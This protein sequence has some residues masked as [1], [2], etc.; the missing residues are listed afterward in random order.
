MGVEALGLYNSRRKEDE[1]D[2]I[3]LMI[4]AEAGYDLSAVVQWWETIGKREKDLF[5]RLKRQHDDQVMESKEWM[6][7]HLHV[8][9]FQGVNPPLCL[10]RCTDC[11]Q[12]TSRLNRLRRLAPQAE[13]IV[14]QARESTAVAR[15]HSIHGVPLRDLEGWRAFVAPRDMCRPERTEVLDQETEGT[16]GVHEDEGWA[17]CFINN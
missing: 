17:W 9:S 3:G 8:R 4:M 7:T 16:Q 5:K 6:R 11:E 2:Y 12:P 15:K 1:A 10:Q 14:R 13:A